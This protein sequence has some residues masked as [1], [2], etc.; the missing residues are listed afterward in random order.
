MTPLR[1]AVIGVGHL[2]YHHARLYNA[3]E[4]AHLAGVVDTDRER[5][6][7]VAA[8]FET[9]AFDSIEEL[10]EVG[11]DAASVAVPTVAHRDAAIALL[12]GG[13]D[14]L[15]E[16]PIA[17]SPA[18]AREMIEAARRFG[19][20]LQVGH[21]ERFNGAVIALLDAIKRPRFIECHRMSP[22]PNRGQDVSVVHDLMIHDLDVLLALDDSEIVSVDSIGVPI[23][24]AAEDIANAR[25]RFASGCVANLTAS[26]ISLERMRKIRVFSETAYVSTDY[27][28]QQVVVYGKKPGEIPPGTSP[29]EMITIEPLEVRKEE[30]LRLELEAF[31]TSVRD[32]SAPVVT[33]EDGLRALELAESIINFMR[34]HR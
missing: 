2:G 17:A 28:E 15:V 31:L 33:G 20:L 7:K 5:A 1:T 3:I 34:A 6:R 32:R 18:E 30:P 23:F 12:A 19:R 29:M 24:S 8:E 26:R 10:L 14:A 22:Y 13:V 27:S 21:V 9:R 11:V 4:S 25:I 16:K